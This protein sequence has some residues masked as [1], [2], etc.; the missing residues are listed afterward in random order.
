MAELVMTPEEEGVLEQVLRRCLSDLEL[1]ILHTDH[2]EFRRL[3]QGRRQVL[4]GLHAQLT[5]EAKTQPV[6]EPA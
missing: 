3:L 5:R 6:D 1:E 4:Q 2:A